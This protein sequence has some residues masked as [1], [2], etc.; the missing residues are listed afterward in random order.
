M[1]R[2]TIRVDGVKG[3]S[4][5]VKS[6]LDRTHS[7]AIGTVEDIVTGPDDVTV[8]QNKSEASAHLELEGMDMQSGRLIFRPARQESFALWKGRKLTCILAGGE[9]LTIRAEGARD[10]KNGNMITP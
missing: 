9:S 6:T 4:I 3:D 7:L 8:I 10:P 2:F 5:K 1:N